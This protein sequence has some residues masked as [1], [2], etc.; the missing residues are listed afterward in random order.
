MKDTIGQ[1]PVDITKTKDGL[2]V[3]FHPVAKNAKHP[4]AKV[5]QI[6]LSKSD[7]EKLQKAL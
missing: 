7:L 1:R 2:K 6:T 5:F 3:V 4:D